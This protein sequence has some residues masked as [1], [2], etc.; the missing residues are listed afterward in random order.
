MYNDVYDTYTISFYIP[1]G[2]IVAAYDKDGKI[3][4]TIERFKNVKLPENIL[5]A[6]TQRFPNWAIVKDAYKINYMDHAGVTKKEYKIKLKNG[7]KRMTVKVNE[8]GDFL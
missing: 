2:R 1:E 5:M 3:I 8:A 7:D 4:R 6:V